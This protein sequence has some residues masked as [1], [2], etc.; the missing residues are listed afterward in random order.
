MARNV[1]RGLAR[2]ALVAAAMAV[3]PNPADSQLVANC[4]DR[5]QVIEFLAQKYTEKPA[6]VGLINQRAVMEVYAADN[7]TW[8][9]VVTDVAG[10]SCV[11]LAGTS[12]ETTAPI[13]P[14]A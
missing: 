3:Y 8:T 6:A 2:V 10:R 12:W 5:S 4:A 13:G 11:I 14:K 9:L 1:V 7:G